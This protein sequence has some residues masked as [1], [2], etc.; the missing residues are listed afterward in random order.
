MIHKILKKS[1]L[2]CKSCQGKDRERSAPNLYEQKAEQFLKFKGYR[3]LG[4][5]FRTPLGEIDI[6]GR[7]SRSVA[8]VEVKA[9]HCSFWGDPKEAVNEKK[10]KR[11]I[12]AAKKYIS[13]RSEEYYRFDVV[14][15]VYGNQW[16][17]Y[18]LFKGAFR[19]G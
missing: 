13:S 19:A 18:R 17:M 7:D 5:N 15:I 11:I 6:I 4:R 3:I 10:Q 1:C 16:R 12:C 9:R 8:F 14:T 2:S